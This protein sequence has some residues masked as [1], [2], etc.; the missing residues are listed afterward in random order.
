MAVS[1]LEAPQDSYIAEAKYKPERL[2]SK[3]RKQGISGPPPSF[4]LGNTRDVKK[5]IQ[6]SKPSKVP[7]DE[8]QVV[9]HNYSSTLFPFHEQ[10]RKEYDVVREISMCTSLDLGKPSYQRK[11][12]GPLL[13]QGI[14]TSN[15]TI[16]AHQRRT[17]APELYP[18]K[19]KVNMPFFSGSSIVQTKDTSPT[20]A[21]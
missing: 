11:E 13:G 10:C 9:T 1:L 14:L 16:W 18:Q 15:G 4:L 2:R 6:Y 21:I 20:Y 19:V 12:L 7:C 8:E 17:L 3:L 5:K